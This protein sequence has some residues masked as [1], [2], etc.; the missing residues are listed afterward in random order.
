MDH[1]ITIRTLVFN[2][3]EYSQPGMGAGIVA[4]SVPQSEHVGG[5]RQERRHGTGT[6]ARQG[7]VVT[8]RLLLID[9]YDSFTYNLVQA[10]THS[11][12]ASERLP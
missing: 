4:D 8:P 9:N 7:G 10:F 6:R 2:G 5:A 1:A 11:R 12:S 3:D